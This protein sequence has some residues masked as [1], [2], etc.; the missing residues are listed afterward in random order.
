MLRLAVALTALVLPGLAHA[1]C[2][3]LVKRAESAKGEALVGAYKELLACDKGKAEAAYNDFLKHTGDVP[4]MV[5]LSLA[6][7]EHQVFLPVWTSL[8]KLKD[9]SARDE[10]AGAI[11]AACQDNAQVAVFLKGAYH[12]LK[13]IQFSQWDDA[14][15]ACPDPDLNA[16]LLDRIQD[17]PAMSFDEKYGTILSIWVARHGASA[18]DSLQAAAVTA[19]KKDGPFNSILESMDRAV[20]PASYGA[21]V[22]P[23]DAKRLSEA[24]V[25]IAKQVDP[26][27]AR[28]VADRLYNGGFEAQA[29]SLLPRVYP[30]RV[31]GSGDLLYGVAAVE[32]C[33]TN[34]VVHYATVAEPAKRWSIQA[35]V[36]PLARAFKP[37]L[38][39]SGD[40]WIV[41][42]T[43]EPVS[44]AKDV[45]SWVDGLLP[46][47]ST[48][49]MTVKKAS[50]K[51]IDLP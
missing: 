1:N 45:D 39:C 30:D 34:V 42:V 9:Y 18:I 13:N 8:E 23:A 46:Q 33:D 28:F 6:A 41:L 37:K 7:I 24:L 10:A 51:G 26:E 17:P 3:V 29:A 44:S 22:S 25:A 20:Q 14:Y 50:E 19:S 43:P 36:E 16:W 5:G 40:P 4:T 49:G 35:D 31:Q 11:G 47:W 21:E 38:K 2:D 12:G 48:K 15:V 32:T 27:R